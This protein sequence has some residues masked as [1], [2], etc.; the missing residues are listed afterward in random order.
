MTRVDGARLYATVFVEFCEQCCLTDP[1]SMAMVSQVP[2]IAGTAAIPIS[3]HQITS[4][5]INEKGPNHV[6][7]PLSG[8]KRQFV[9]R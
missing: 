7:K 4:T 6:A 2:G 9:V 5:K 3:P 1:Y 8:T